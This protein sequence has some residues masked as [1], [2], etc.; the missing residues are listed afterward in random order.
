M[1]IITEIINAEKISLS[2]DD[3]RNITNNKVSIYMYEDLEKFTSIDQILLPYNSIILLYQTE[4]ENIGHWVCL[5]KIN[6]NTLEFFDSLGYT[7]DQELKLSTYNIRV[8]NGIPVPHLTHLISLSNYKLICNTVKFQENVRDVNTCGRWVAVRIRLKHL[9]LKKFT[10][11]FHN[12]QYQI[13]DFWI[14]A[15]TVLFS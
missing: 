2:D 14:S 5:M 8:H 6:D 4:A 3:L 7:V 9:S 13:P 12:L 11:L 10:T 15:V 1:S